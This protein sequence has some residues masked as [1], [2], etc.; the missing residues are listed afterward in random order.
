MRVHPSRRILAGLAFV[1]AGTTSSLAADAQAFGERLK[2]LMAEQQVTLAYAGAT[3]EGDDVLLSGATVRGSEPGEDAVTLGDL[4]FENVTGSTPEGWRV[5]RLAPA[6]IDRTD[7]PTRTRVSGIVV[8]GLQIPPAGATAP[9]AASPMF[10]DRAAVGSLTA[11][12]DGRP[13][14]T[15]ESIELRTAGGAEAGYSGTFGVQRFTADTQASGGGRGSTVMADLGYP[16]LTGNVS[17]TGSWNPQSGALTLDPLQVAVDD[18]GTLKF[19]YTITGYTPSFIQSLGQISQQMQASGGQNE[20]AGMA[21]I[22]LISQ[23]YLQSAELAFTDNSLTNRL[24]DYYAKQNNQTREQMVTGLVGSLP[25]ALG[26]LQNPEFQAEVTAA[27]KDFLE[28]PKALRIAIAPAAPVP[29]TQ[30]LGAAMG[31]PQTLPQVLNL[32]VR[33]GN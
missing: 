24:L 13:V 28:N 9:A 30:I 32:S 7:G 12:R 16:Q 23:L 8:E 15:A 10:F 27:V 20:G 18:A 3:S 6:D 1:L 26:Y 17:G 4:R 5:Q 11:E 14:V 31:A 21:V 33:S 22:G 25:L 2:G 29:A 19:A